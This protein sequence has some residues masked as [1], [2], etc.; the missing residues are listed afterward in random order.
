[1]SS[2]HDGAMFRSL[3]Q[4]ARRRP[5]IALRRWR[6]ISTLILVFVS[7]PGFVGCQSLQKRST[8]RSAQCGALC[9]QARAARD[10]GNSD[11]ANQYINEAL[12]Q[13]PGDSETRRQLAETMWNNGRRTEAIAQFAALCERYPSDAKFA[14]RM[15]VMQWES[16]QHSTAA[17]SALSALQLDPQSKEALLIKARVEAE[18]G[19]LDGALVSYLRLSQV[20][21][22]DLPTLLELGELH[23]RRGNP[24]RACPLIRTAMQHPQATP[25]QRVEIEWLLGV[26]YSRNERWSAAV[27]ALERAIISRTASADDWCFLAWA[28]MQCGDLTGAQSDLQRA[29]QSE[30]DSM[31]ARKLAKL[32]ESSRGTPLL[33]HNVTPASYRETLR[34]SDETPQ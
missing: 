21:P 5:T 20:A 27:A 33:D 19:D 28:R 2:N 23:L 30:P 22:D 17:S 1:M 26:A 34:S 25:Q 11:Q 32:L 15:A 12:R 16:H 24:D 14:A 4:N 3:T 7:W 9:A 18:Q 6:G 10:E 31:S 29:L 13:K 8:Q